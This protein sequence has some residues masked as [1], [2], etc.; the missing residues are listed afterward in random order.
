MEWVDV[1]RVKVD[2]HQPSIEVANNRDVE[3]ERFV[4]QGKVVEPMLHPLK[5]V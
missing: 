1:T 5:V 4:F 2:P 3:L